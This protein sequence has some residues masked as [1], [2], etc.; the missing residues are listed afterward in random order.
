MAEGWSVTAVDDLSS[1]QQRV[2]FLKEIGVPL[3]RT[4]IR[5]EE[6]L[7]AIR[8]A[9]P[10]TIFHLA[11]QMDVR[12]SVAD[13]SFDASVNVLGTLNILSAA[14]RS[15]GGCSVIFASSGG[16]IYGEPGPEDLPVKESHVG[17]PTSPYGISKK[18]AEDYLRFYGDA[19]GVEFASLALANVYG[20]RQDPHGE[21]GVVSIF[22]S[23][24]NAGEPCVIYG[25]GKQT[26]DFVYVGDVARAFVAAAKH[27]GNE[28]YNIGTGIETSINDLYETMAKL[29][30]VESPPTYKEARTGELQ[31]NALDHTKATKSLAWTPKTPLEEGLKK[32]LAWLKTEA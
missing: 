18:V 25:D 23:R 29:S 4:D 19:M 11:A 6:A 24:L 1:G 16:C 17:R 8:E 9:N 28:T 5:S 20:P 14:H 2:G 15:D 3:I 21:A 32:T 12:R 30:E 10:Q 31:R 27:R 7:E 26:R 22:G 13:P